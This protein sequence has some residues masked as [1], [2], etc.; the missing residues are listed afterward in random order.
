MTKKDQ[1]KAILRILRADSAPQS[2][3]RISEQ[4]SA[5]GN[6]IGE[7]SVRLYLQEM[8]KGGLTRRKGRGHIITERG[9][10]ELYSTSALQRVGFM[11][12]RIDRMTYQMDFDLVDRSGSVI[13]NVTMVEPHELEERLDL[14]CKVYESGYAMGRLLALFGPGDTIGYRIVPR[15]MVGIGTVSSIALNGVLLKHGIP[16][17]SR[18]G[19]LLEL[20]AGKPTRFVEIINYEGTSI[21]PLEVFISSGMTNYVGAVKTGDGRIGA[22]FR[23]FPAESKPRVEELAEKLDRVGLGGFLSVGM[24]GQPLLDISVSEGCVGSIVIGGLNPV[25]ILEETGLRAR[26]YSLAG[27]IRYQLLFPYQELRD[28]VSEHL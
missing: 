9:L 17:N 13:V 18:F 6:G 15:G 2:S 19:G 3:S 14:I 16:A 25:A 1:Q 23:E 12:A 7:R 4:L 20:E 28:R 11:S 8:G 26:S 5:I 22:G 27:L 21:D 10:A 24:P